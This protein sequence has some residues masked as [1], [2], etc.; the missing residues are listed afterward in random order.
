MVVKM[1]TDMRAVGY[2]N[3]T[4]NRPAIFLR[5]MLNLVSDW[6][7]PSLER[8]PAKKVP[9]FEERQRQRFLS[10]FEMRALINAL[11][12]DENVQAV[13]AIELLLLT[14]ARRNEITQARWEH[15]NLQQKTMLVPLAARRVRPK[16][17]IMRIGFQHQVCA[18]AAEGERIAKLKNPA[19]PFGR[20]G[21]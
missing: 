1:M 17:R 3:G 13:K 16:C 21:F 20:R 8:N 6:G 19:V 18:F 9:L 4:C 14:G 2:A 12:N 15:I 10:P 11:K 5:Y 7:I